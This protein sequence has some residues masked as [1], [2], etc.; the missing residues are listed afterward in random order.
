MG[1]VLQSQEWIQMNHVCAKNSFTLHWPKQ[2][3]ENDDL[4]NAQTRNKLLREQVEKLNAEKQE[5]EK[6]I[7]IHHKYEEMS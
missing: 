6:I 7:S 2:K 3:L 1:I 5:Q 4:L